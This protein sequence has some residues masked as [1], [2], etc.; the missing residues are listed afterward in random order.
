MAVED[1]TSSSGYAF[2]EIR[3][4]RRGTYRLIIA[5][6]VLAEHQFDAANSVLRASV[7]VR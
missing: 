3:N 1:I 7:T 2:F 6:V 4:V 5:D